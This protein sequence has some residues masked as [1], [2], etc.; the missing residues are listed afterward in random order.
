MI[1]DFM[2]EMCALA[3]F[4]LAVLMLSLTLVDWL[5]S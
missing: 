1:D 5:V 3:V 2:L 4:A